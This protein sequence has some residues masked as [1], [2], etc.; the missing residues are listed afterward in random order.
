MKYSI[1][2]PL[3]GPFEFE[4][5]TDIDAYGKFCD[6]AG[7]TVFAA[8]TIKE[9]ELTPARGWPTIDAILNTMVRSPLLSETYLRRA[10]KPDYQ[11]RK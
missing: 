8:C 4:A 2:S 6:Q 11:G 5:D 10:N 9:I 7:Y 1:R 3:A